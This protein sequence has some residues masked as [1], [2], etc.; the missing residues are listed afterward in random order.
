MLVGKLNVAKVRTRVPGRYGDGGG[1][2]LVVGKNS[3]SWVFRYMINGRA[4]EMGLGSLA[5]IGL[6]EAREAA[7]L[8]RL[9]VHQKPEAG[10]PV[11]PLDERHAAE[12]RQRFETGRQ[13]TFRQCAEAC[14]AAN[15]EEWGNAKHAQQWRNSLANYAYA[16]IGD[17]PVQLIDTDAIV[18]LLRPIWRTKAVTAARVRGRIEKVFDWATAAKLREGENPAARGPLSIL[19]GKQA[20]QVKHHAALKPEEMH[21]F[22]GALRERGTVAA[23]AFE[24]AILTATRTQEALKAQW[25][26]IKGDVWVVPAERMKGRKGKRRPHAVPLSDDAKKVIQKMEAMRRGEFIFPGQTGSRPLGDKAMLDE[27]DAM[28]YDDR[29]TPHGARSTF[30]DWCGDK[31]NFPREVAEAAL[32]HRVGNAAEQAYRRSTAL[33]KRRQLMI[34]WAEFIDAPPMSSEVVPI[35]RAG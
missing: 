27:R 29:M 25:E 24:F 9:Q 26:E 3:K 18:M 7:R 19:L 34:K 20:R 31:T 17:I 28:G 5:D 8:C 2:W 10:G 16:R 14:M 33:E 23:A 21:D 15:A 35:R 22:V 11:D 32:A 12:L 4:R 13:K 1:L 6:A 30:R